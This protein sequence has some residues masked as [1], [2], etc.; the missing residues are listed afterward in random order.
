MKRLIILFSLYIG[1]VFNGWSQ[2]TAAEYFVDEDPGIGSATSLSV[3]S[4]NAIS[5]NYTIPTTGLSTGLHV[6][7]VRVKGTDNIWSLYYRDYFYIHTV[8][9]PPVATNIVQAE[10]FV[11][12]DPGVG[13]ATPLP[14]SAGQIIDET[15]SIP[16]SG[17]ANGLHVLQVRIKD[18]ADTWSLY[19]RDYF[20]IQDVSS[21]T[22]SPITDAEYF[23]DTDPGIGNGTSIAV[24][25]GFN[26]DESFVIPVP[27]D[28]TDGTHYLYFRVKNMDD[29]WSVY[30]FDVFNVDSSLSV[31][32]FGEQNFKIF[33][34][35]TND[36]LNIK[37][38]NSLDYNIRVYDI[39][40]RE[41][42]S[43]NVSNLE[44]TLDF[45]FLAK[46]VYVI[47]ITD[48]STSLSTTVK[49]IKS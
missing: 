2:I 18:G 22:S 3:I 36:V 28:I 32:D 12:S 40:G 45:S 42:I 43:K 29:N 17:L 4:G 24:T 13:S 6:L 9:T 47:T 10:Y 5:E 11:D 16:T 20:F 35:P 31:L 21:F 19:Y 26:I 39:N 23:F 27:L 8:E 15:F 7:H 37:F 1:L 46:G 25:E 49:V 14:V 41:F 44:Q 34:N 30:V 33:P 48:Q 38:E